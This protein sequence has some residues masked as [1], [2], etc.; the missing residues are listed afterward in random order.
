MAPGVFLSYAWRLAVDDQLS[1]RMRQA[2]MWAPRISLS[3]FAVGLIVAMI[4]FGG[5]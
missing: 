3:L 1:K 5:L 2:H 4:K